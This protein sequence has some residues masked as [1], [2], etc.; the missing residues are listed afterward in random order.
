MSSNI[1]FLLASRVFSEFSGAMYNLVLPLYILKIT[2]S[3]AVTGLFFI[4]AM[5]PSTLLL[6]VLGVIIENKSKRQVVGIGLLLIAS[7]FIVQLLVVQT[8]NEELLIFI[9][10]IL[11]AIFNILNATS[12]IASKVLFSSLVP[13]NFLEKYNALK[14][15]FD[16]VSLFIAPM[17]GTLINGLLNFSAVLVFSLVLTVISSI[18]IFKI[19]GIL[20]IKSD[21]KVSFLVNF[22]AGFNFVLE[23]KEVLNYV[24]LVTSLNFFVASS[25]EVIN[26]GILLQKYKIP[27]EIFGLSSLA[28]TLGVTLS[29]IL[30][31]RKQHIDLKKYLPYLFIINS[32]VMVI[33]GLL[34]IVMF[35]ADKYIY[36]LFFLILQIIMGFITILVNVPMTSYFQSNVPI[37]FQAR[38]FAFYVFVATLSVPFGIAY[39]GFLAQRIG[40]DVAYICNNICVI[41]VVLVVFR[42]QFKISQ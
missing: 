7:I 20:E 14:S 25:E 11:A 13:N 4:L 15:I 10:G 1:K 21:K 22:K 42:K 19:D 26:P 23:N 24:L 12:D 38:F 6:P 30:I 18:F 33:V 36:L 17:I 32:F 28:F 5:L 40:A 8:S 35:G 37:E 34:S 2:N 3:L 31:A 27:T 16:N 9:L 29:G 41:L 39:S